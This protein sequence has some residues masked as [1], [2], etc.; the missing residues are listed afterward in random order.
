MN[1]ETA[2][3]LPKPTEEK[4]TLSKAQKKKLKAK[5]KDATNKADADDNDPDDIEEAKEPKETNDAPKTS[6]NGVK[7]DPDAETKDDAPVDKVEAKDKAVAKKDSKKDD[8]KAK[9]DDKKGKPM[10]AMA[11]LAQERMLQKRLEEEA[12]KREEEELQRLEE[13]R[14]KKEE[15]E[16]Q[17]IKAAKEKKEK[18]RQDRIE[19]LKKE[20]KYV[21]DKERKKQAEM[22]RARE[23][24]LAGGIKIDALTDVAPA[25][26][27]KPK[28]KMVITKKRRP[29]TKVEGTTAVEETQKVEDEAQKDDEETKEDKNAVEPKAEATDLDWQSM[30]DDDSSTT[31]STNTATTTASAKNDVKIQVID[32]KIKTDAALENAQNKER[33]LLK[34]QKAAAANAKKDKLE[35]YEEQLKK[36]FEAKDKGEKSSKDK[37]GGDKTNKVKS[38]WAEET[39]EDDGPVNLRSPICCILGHVDTG[40]TKL[41]DKM[42]HTN[43]QEDEAGGITQQIGATFFPL[44]KLQEEISK[45]ESIYPVPILVPGLLV[46]DTPGHESFSNL[47]SRGSG[48]CDIAI[49]VVDIMHGLQK[50]TLESIELLKMRKTPFVIALNK[51]DRMYGWKPDHNSCSQLTLRKQDKNAQ[52][53][54]RDR[55][56]QIITALAEQGLNTALYYENPDPKT[57]VS[58]IPTSAITGEGI[59]DLLSV[60]VNLTQNFLKSKIKLK[61]DEFKCTVLEVKVIEGLGT[62]IDVILVNGSLK[63]GDKIILCGFN[64][65]IITSIRALLTPHP[66]KE[67]RVKNEYDHHK[68]LQASMGIKVCANDLEN[69]LAGSELFVV[70]KDSDIELYTQILSEDIEKI[71]KS[72]QLVALGVSVTA[73]TLGSLEALLQFLKQSKIPVSNISI[74]PVSKE[75]VIKAMKPLLVEDTKV[76]KEYATIL[77]FDVKVLAE[78]QEFAETNGVKIFTANIIYHLFDHFMEYLNQIREE[79]KKEEGKIAV[80]PCIIKPVAFF[81]K[82]DPI[83]MGI[84][85]VEGVIRLGTPLCVQTNDKEKIKIG[86]VDSIEREH[87]PMQQAKI[88]DGSVAIRLKG[89]PAIM[90]GRHFELKDKFVSIL[91]RDSIDAL[92]E[93]FR[94]EMSKSDWELVKKLKSHFNII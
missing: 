83:V 16:A 40:K 39:K 2:T 13:E 51:I 45:L 84:D 68:E 27:G 48:L 94:D 80:F 4:K 47:R 74:G 9:K 19:Q 24:L 15:E 12:R 22:Q 85:V 18:E 72:I 30:L 46:I 56:K 76:Q 75:E 63:V 93:Y 79:R 10:N 38:D 92:K 71:R 69:A 52:L 23:Q 11:K 58:I 60:V 81:N 34:E 1:S 3:E 50:Q 64:G 8:K 29:Q 62:T 89:D 87:K 90:A 43:V 32:D 21:T 41:L 49:L 33:Q 88:T 37:K 54:F 6:E 78:A 36:K 14:I 55:A 26:D 77:A 31:N 86:V 65:P 35:K 66:M 59:P 25:E 17:L 42:R 44:T 82:K 7:I 73:S 61:E 91:T 20:G 67:M 53:E 28:S 57:Y 70:E 5:Q